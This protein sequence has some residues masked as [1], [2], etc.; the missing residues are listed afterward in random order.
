V[1]VDSVE[2]V[3]NELG[4]VYES[5]GPRFMVCCP[6]H[7]DNEPSCGVW[8]DSGAFLC[9]G[10]G[11]EGSL[12]KL[13][14]EVKGITL[15]EARRWIKGED[16][17]S[18]MEKALHRFLD[19]E[20]HTFRYFKMRSFLSTYPSVFKYPDGM[21]YL[22]R[23]GGE[24]EGRRLNKEIIKHFRIRWGGNVRKY[25]NR[26]VIPIRTDSGKLL[27]YVGRTIKK[28]VKPKT[29]KA[30]SSPHRT[31]FGLYELLKKVSKKDLPFQ[32]LIIVEGEFDAI[33][34]QQHG[35]PA[36]ANMG[37]MKMSPMKIK[38]LR[39]Y[40][41]GV[42][43]SYDGDLA[44][45]NAMYGSIDKH[46]KIHPGEQELLDPYIPTIC[47]NLPDGKDPN[48][49]SDKQITGIYGQWRLPCL[50]S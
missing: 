3:L 22:Q 30:R 49:L 16:N 41:R 24:P 45:R 27:S 1:T 31:F 9:F 14:S 5:K 10:C 47:I 25:R 26:V 32:Y 23:I 6:Y 48:N 12:A 13:V 20:N 29:R 17:I 18:D 15:P 2:K 37:T 7:D 50:I 28:D 44:G 21:D 35:I 43:L 42:I 34:L 40:S 38:L 4:I 33:Y 11:E 19:N 39:K 8:R 46:G 36:I